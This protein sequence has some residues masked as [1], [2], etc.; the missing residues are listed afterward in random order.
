MHVCRRVHPPSPP[1]PRRSR[2]QRQ[3]PPRLRKATKR[4]RYPPHSDGMELPR[5]RPSWTRSAS[6]GR[7]ALRGASAPLP[8]AWRR[9][10]R[11]G[12]TGEVSQCEDC[13]V[14][15]AGV[16]LQGLAG[17]GLAVA[18][19]GAGTTDFALRPVWVP[20]GYGALLLASEDWQR[21]CEAGARLQPNFAVLDPLNFS[22]SNSCRLSD[23]DWECV[24][25]IASRR[26]RLVFHTAIFNRSKVHQSP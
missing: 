10:E 26:G 4:S 21:Y 14:V 2:P 12:L 6:T 18:G 8:R 5:A 11:T 23:R 22:K 7:R 1:V 15:L 20:D 24:R 17:I 16:A 9:A 13:G 19:G 3:C 25:R